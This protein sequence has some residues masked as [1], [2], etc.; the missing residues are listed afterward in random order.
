MEA[1]FNSKWLRFFDETISD[2][3]IAL[4]HPNSAITL[5][6]KKAVFKFCGINSKKDIA[7]IDPD[8]LFDLLWMRDGVVY[9]ELGHFLYSKFDR[10]PVEEAIFN[11]F[12]EDDD[13]LYTLD[14][15]LADWAPQ[16]D[17]MKGAMLRFAELGLANAVTGTRL[18]NEYAS[19][20]WFPDENEEF[21]VSRSRTSVGLDLAFVKDDKFYDFKSIISEQPAVYE[22]LETRQKTIIHKIPVILSI[23]SYEKG[24]KTYS[25]VENCIMEVF[26]EKG[27]NGTAEEI[28]EKCEY[29]EELRDKYVKTDPV[30]KK[31]IEDQLKT[32]ENMLEHDVF[33][34]IKGILKRRKV[35][36]NYES[37]WDFIVSRC[38][39]IGLFEILPEGDFNSP[40][41]DTYFDFDE[42]FMTEE[43]KQ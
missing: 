42:D 21:F 12:R 7:M 16:R 19:D 29:W 26:K 24:T 8:T 39:E 22:F 5:G 34:I 9:H 31:S 35:M 4:K 11:T 43:E 10:N 25:E 14:E 32:Q 2:L 6:F 30:L 33:K 15:L 38:K 17:T 23:A 3:K 13:V 27:T 37:L 40:V 20:N 18:L 36:K 28:K 1:V 41:D